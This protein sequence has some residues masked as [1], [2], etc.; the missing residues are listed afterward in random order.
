MSDLGNDKIQER[1]S[2]ATFF[3]LS[4]LV[5]LSALI[6]RFFHWQDSRFE[7]LNVQA[8]V[9]EKYQ[10]FAKYLLEDGFLSFFDSQSRISTNIDL[11]GHPPGYSYLIALIFGVTGE[12]NQTIQYVSIFFDSLSA[13]LIF[14]IARRLF[15]NKIG[16]IAGLLSAFSPQFALNSNFL[17]PDTLAIFPILLAVLFLIY[18]VEKPHYIYL[19]LIGICLGLSCWLR[20]NALL[21][22]VFFVFAIF[23]IIKEKRF[24]YPAILLMAFC[25]TIA[26]I[27]IRNAIVHKSFIPISLGS[28]Q[29]ILEGI[30]DYDPEQRFGFSRWDVGIQKKEA[31]IFNRPDYAES[32]FGPDGVARDKMRINQGWQVIR[33]NPFWFGKVMFQRA[34]TMLRLERMNLVSTEIPVTNSLQTNDLQI[35]WKTSPDELL[36][37]GKK[38]STEAS[39]AISNNNFQLKT[40]NSKKGEQFATPRF[41][42]E[43]HKDY[44]ANVRLLITQGRVSLRMK[45]EQSNKIYALAD[46]VFEESYDNKYFYKDVGM[47]FV[48]TQNE[49]VHIIFS[50]DVS[51]YPSSI[52]DVEKIEVFELGESSFTWAWVIRWVVRMIQ[53]L[54]I[55]AVII[56]LFVFGLAILV[57]RKQWKNL[58][59][60]LIVPLY[61]MS[62]QSA[63]HT[64]YRYVMAMLHFY[65]VFAVVFLVNAADF[66][67]LRWK[68]VREQN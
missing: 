44:L 61:Y 51:E 8:G 40:D 16:L 57:Y 36:K 20:A 52:L 34:L 38:L 56:P 28:G 43:K 37:D 60:L 39:L 65:F 17:L 35:K 1:P 3:S 2:Q 45:G 15:S 49:S 42:L 32:L 5:F 68:S 19:I 29:T 24:V 23:L 54:F 13:V 41:D 58:I 33:E 9:V 63:L 12:F 25:L 47:P 62:V 55:T 14:L 22:S 27:T 48:M 46:V 4:F 6:V 11:M 53:K 67:R 7:V 66:L 64:E 59:I 31:E 30:A 26:P 18:F 21:M 50:N 10:Q